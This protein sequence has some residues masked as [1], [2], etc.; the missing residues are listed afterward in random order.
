MGKSKKIW[1]FFNSFSAQRFVKRIGEEPMLRGYIGGS[2]SQSMMMMLTMTYDLSWW[3]WWSWWSLWSWRSAAKEEI[4]SQVFI[5]LSREQM[6]RY[7]CIHRLAGSQKKTGSKKRT[8]SGN[9]WKEEGTP[10]KNWRTRSSKSFTLQS[11]N[12]RWKSPPRREGETPSSL[13]S[14]IVKVLP[15]VSQVLIFSFYH[16]F[17]QVLSS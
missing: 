3:S 15:R 7:G 4:E 9:Y 10:Q 6:V 2:S 5:R 17:T 16:Q 13:G 12:I 1:E 8:N 14:V 11:S